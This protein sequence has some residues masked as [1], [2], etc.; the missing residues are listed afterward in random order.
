M[1]LPIVQIDRILRQHQRPRRTQRRQAGGSIVAQHCETRL[2]GTRENQVHVSISI[3]VGR[4][5]VRGH[6]ARIEDS[7][8]DKRLLA[9]KQ[10]ADAG[11]I[12][13]GDDNVPA[14]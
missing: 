12:S 1:W 10:N 4:G 11:G 14:A 2:V 8:G 9:G 5:H 6:E 13:M 7:A 3:K